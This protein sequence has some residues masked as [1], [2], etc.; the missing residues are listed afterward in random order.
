VE[1]AG[2]DV[3]K[4]W[5]SIEEVVGAALSRVEDALGAREVELEIPHDLP[6][7]PFDPVSIE[8]VL[9]NLVENAIKYSP[10][11][12]PLTLRAAAGPSEVAVEVMDRG[13][14]IEPGEEERLFEKFYRGA[15]GADPGGMGLGLAICRAIVVAHGGTI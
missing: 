10:P 9:L 4:E 6:L 15:Q 12:T 1:A 13:P 14:G 2:I 8:Q 5:H 3:K 11:G 7:A